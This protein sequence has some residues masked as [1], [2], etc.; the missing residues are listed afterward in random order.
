VIAEDAEMNV[1]IFV[2]PVEIEH[3]EPM[4]KRMNFDNKEFDFLYEAHAAA[5]EVWGDKEFKKGE[6]ERFWD[7]RS[8]DGSYLSLG[9]NE[10][11][12]EKADFCG[13][14]VSVEKVEIK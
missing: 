8:A 11:T 6:T 5:E 12:G 1:Y 4:P 9:V 3:L 13:R 14:I 2:Q 10:L 7:Y